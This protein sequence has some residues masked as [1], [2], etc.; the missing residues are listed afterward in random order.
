MHRYHLLSTQEEH[1]LSRKGTEPPH[2][3]AYCE[4]TQPGIYLCKR[5]DAPLFFSSDKFGCSCGWPSFDAPI[6]EAVLQ[7]PDP[8][9]QRTEILCHRCHGHLGHLFLGERLTS[10]NA[11]YCV[12]SLSIRFVPAMTDQGYERALF[13]GGCFWGVEHYLKQIPGVVRVTSGYIGG[14]VAQPT[15]EEVCSGN[16]CHAEAVEVLFD[17]HKTSY[18]TLARTF[19]E[20]H[21][22]TQKDRQGPDIGKQ[23]RSAIFYLTEAQKET[24][25]ELIA[26]LKKRGL[27]VVTQLQP[28]SLFYPAEDY[29]QDHY[30]KTGEEP[31]CHHRVR[32]F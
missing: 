29:H 13:A 4:L 21:D 18:E 1:V 9:G 3:G 10:K 14:T 8:D 22:P 6:P 5:C 11:R 32:R 17:P 31:Y 23:Y 12:N 30:A 19:F 25:E 7:I 28:A 2:Q 16:T 20:I 27:K 24:A 26:L 15:Y